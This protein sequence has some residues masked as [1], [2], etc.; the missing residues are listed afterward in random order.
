MARPAIIAV[1]DD[2]QVLAEV[3]ADLRSHYREHYRIVG[4]SSGARALEAV[5]ELVLRG[6]EVALFLV[7]QRMPV[8]SGTDFLLASAGR[9]PDAKRVLLTAYADTDTAI[10]SINTVNLDHYLLKPWDPPE[11]ALYP[12]LDDL[13]DDWQA[14]RPPAEGGI[15]VLGM[16]W[17]PATHDVKD[18]LARN[19]VPY[20]FLDVERDP[21]ATRLLEAMPTDEP[22]LPV[23][24][25]PDGDVLEAPEPR[26]LA[27]RIGLHVQ[28]SAPFYDLVVV[29]AGPA[30]LAAAVY[31]ATEGLR[32]AV[33]E[34]QA[35]G[36]QAGS[37]S[38]IENYLGFPKGISGLDLARRATA[39][40]V[41]FGA[42][43]LTAADVVQLRVEGPRRTIVLGDGAE[44]SS[45]A[46]IIA[47]GMTTRTLDVPG[48]ERLTGK[49]VYYG[50]TLSEAAAFAGE[51]VF[52]VGGANSAGQGA[53]W[54]A[55]HA[56]T[57]TLLVRGD[58][59]AHKMSS[60]LVDQLAELGNVE[61]LCDTEVV[62]VHG[63]D[64]LERVV[65][66]DGRAGATQERAGAG[67]FVF[68]GAVPHTGFVA[69]VVE[70][71]AR[72]FILTGPELLADGTRP[73]GWTVDRD[74]LPF[75]TSVPGVFAA[76]DVRDGAIR[77]VASAVG[78]GSTCVTM[79]HRYLGMA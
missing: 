6:E 12:V 21:Q 51:D 5:E 66:R 46:V 49:G 74:P 10:A 77:R 71:T 32:V 48:F 26:D 57:V 56:R 34:R 41:R 20:V 79:V 40:A 14:N 59:L 28:A 68:A 35:T 29:G 70:R 8:M 60:Y 33:V 37:S 75:E 42:E 61:V 65:L 17:S 58:S 13:L 11:E 62:S 24:V 15:R 45:H 22:T 63:G 64:R 1:D 25:L 19:Q 55:R 2:P 27:G 9:F 38:R 72:G 4:A 47:S 16:R 23:V 73:A 67:L 52:V 50:A 54:F 39:Q 78:Q 3:R 44:L 69:D 31:G 7:D 76:G 30:G 43:I 36:G 53:V 18:F